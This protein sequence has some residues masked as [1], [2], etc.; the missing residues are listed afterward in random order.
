MK[1]LWEHW[2]YLLNKYDASSYYSSLSPTKP[3]QLLDET[4]TQQQRTRDIF[5]LA[6]QTLAFE[7]ALGELF[8]WPKGVGIDRGSLQ[9]FLSDDYDWEWLYTALAEVLFVLIAAHIAPAL[10]ALRLNPENVC[11]WSPFQQLGAF[12]YLLPLRNRITVSVPMKKKKVIFTSALYY[13]LFY[14]CIIYSIL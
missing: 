13:L 11:Y 1:G 2:G 4:H 5:S 14:E 10:F 12:R 8:V 9:P 7:L 6:A 3:K